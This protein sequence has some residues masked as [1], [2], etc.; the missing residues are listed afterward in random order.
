M[1]PQVPQPEGQG[2]VTPDTMMLGTVVKTQDPA[3][4]LN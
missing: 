4:E 3:I 2:I 1:N